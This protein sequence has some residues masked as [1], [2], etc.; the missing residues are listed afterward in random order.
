MK[1]TLTAV[2]LLVG[3]LAVAAPATAQ[4]GSVRGRVVDAQGEPVVGAAV[5]LEFQ[6]EMTREHEVE[7]N[8]DGEY[9]QVGIYPG[10]YRITV[11]AEGYEPAVI[12]QRITLGDRTEVADI[13]LE[14]AAPKADPAMVKL[15]ETFA[16]AVTLSDAG[17]Y[18]EAA[19]LYQQILEEKPD[20]PEVLENLGYVSVQQKDWATAQASY[21]KALELTPDD[22]E[23]MTALAL[24][25]QK[26]GQGDKASELMAQAAGQNPQDAVAQF[27]SG[28]LKLT[29]GDTVG[30]IEAFQACLAADPEM[31]EAHY[32]LGTLLVG[33]GQVPEAIEHLETYLATNPE[34]EKYVSTA[35]GL[36][37]ALKQ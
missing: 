36:L 18:G 8:D 23:V 22:T 1:N 34:K 32:H 4:T 14:P 17:K 37:E 29:A 5:L 20:I 28:V 15:R 10:P 31:A 35:K 16:E 19:A 13:A 25:Y 33:Q 24:V 27:N 11:R 7:T 9:M 2:A 3:L 6:G 21:E 26:V 12:E 30:A